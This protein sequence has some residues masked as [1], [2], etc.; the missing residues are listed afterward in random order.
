MAA[1]PEPAPKRGLFARLRSGL[2]GCLPKADAARRGEGVP[3]AATSAS[4]GAADQRPVGSPST[5]ETDTVTTTGKNSSSNSVSRSKSVVSSKKKWQRKRQGQRKGLAL[6]GVKIEVRCAKSMAPSSVLARAV[7]ARR[8]GKGLGGY[9]KGRRAKVAAAGAARAAIVNE[10]AAA[11]AAAP[12]SS[13]I[14]S[15]EDVESEAT[16][17]NETA[18]AMAAPASSS[19]S[20]SNTESEEIEAGSI[21]ASIDET[22]TTT[23]ASTSNEGAAV[24]SPPQSNASAA[25]SACV[26]ATAAVGAAA[27]SA[28]DDD[29]EA[30]L[31]RLLAAKKPTIKEQ[32]DAPSQGSSQDW[33]MESYEL[34]ELLAASAEAIFEA[35][36]PLGEGGFGEVRRVAVNG[37]A[38]ALKRAPYGGEYMS[39]IRLGGVAKTG[40]VQVPL[41]AHVDLA[42]EQSYLLFPLACGDLGAAWRRHSAGCAAA[43]EQPEGKA[44]PS[45]AKARRKSRSDSA[46]VGNLTG[47]TS[48][49]KSERYNND[50]SSAAA[51]KAVAAEMVYALGLMHGEGYGHGDLK[52]ANYLVAR[53]GHLRIAD[54]GSLCQVG[55]A[56]PDGGFTLLYA[57]PELMPSFLRKHLVRRW[58]APFD[59]LAADLWALG[60]SW[61]EMQLPGDAQLFKALRAAHKGKSA[62]E[63]ERLA[64]LLPAGLADLVFGGM[65]RRRAG[66]RLTVDAIKAH[67]FF[68]GVDWAAVGE[69]R[70]P[71]PVDLRARLAASGGAASAEKAEE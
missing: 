35:G 45:G 22:M 9:A 44:A 58:G 24:I 71:L 41:A 43:G 40:Y 49:S 13:N 42:K 1:A 12:V 34:E 2:K 31:A 29:F 50:D 53:D 54:L 68:V 32:G 51:F 39:D 46:S 30:F 57:A 64:P 10:T 28:R 66:K 52:P 19:G 23:A 3:P 26:G 63:G 65:L 15:N 14:G 6:R 47:T 4:S 48:S 60:V 17:V 8:G 21:A 61:L 5:A 38:F 7:L 11:A 55:S 25:A 62:R 37:E 70:V 56:W 59:P 36:A 18:A 27:S 20:G 69:R 16:S 67:P 33:T